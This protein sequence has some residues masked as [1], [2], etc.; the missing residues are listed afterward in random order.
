MK[1]SKVIIGTAIFIGTHFTAAASPFTITCRT[2]S[3]TTG[4]LQ[5]AFFPGDRVMVVVTPTFND[6][7]A[8]KKP[9]T[10]TVNAQAAVA[11]VSI[12]YTISNSGSLQNSNPAS[13]RSPALFASGQQVRT[14]KIP[15]LLPPSTLTVSALAGSAPGARIAAESGAAA[16]GAG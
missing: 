11:G 9:I 3:A 13:L 6:A 7:S 5:S 15:R 12:P 1:I 14:F 4:Q 2:Y 16:G 10:L 8:Y